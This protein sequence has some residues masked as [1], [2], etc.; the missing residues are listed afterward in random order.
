MSDPQ[1]DAAPDPAR[2]DAALAMVRSSLDYG[3]SEEDIADVRAVL[4]RHQKAYAKLRA[5]PLRNADEPEF[6]F[7]PYRA[8]G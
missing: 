6:I 4:E 8:E 5:Y 1:A 3:L 7:R 2:V